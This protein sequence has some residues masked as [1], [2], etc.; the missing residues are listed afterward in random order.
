MEKGLEL[1][2]IVPYLS[3]G[4]RTEECDLKKKCFPLQ[5]IIYGTKLLGHLEAIKE[6]TDPNNMLNCMGCIGNNKVKK[7]A[8][9]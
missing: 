6:A 4:Q 8:K 1:N 9:W 2:S 5:E 3:I 7:A